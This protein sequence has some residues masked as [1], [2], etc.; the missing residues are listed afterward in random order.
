MYFHLIKPYPP[1][2][3]TNDYLQSATY[4]LKDFNVIFAIYFHLHLNYDIYF[5]YL[6]KKHNIIN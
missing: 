4:F 3:L 6:N 1:K 5:K 2:A